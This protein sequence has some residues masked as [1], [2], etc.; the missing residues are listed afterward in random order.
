M[1]GP[2]AQA[3]L[4][5][6]KGWPSWPKRAD[7]VA[8][9]RIFRA[10]LCL[11]GLTRSVSTVGGDFS[12]WNDAALVSLSLDALTFVGGDLSVYNNAL[13]CDNTMDVFLLQ[14]TSFTGTVT[15]HDNTGVCTP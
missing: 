12:I 3:R 9:R 11:T 15:R 5:A 6:R 4:G 8:P 2:P 14:L 13:L 10:S 7:R 1:A